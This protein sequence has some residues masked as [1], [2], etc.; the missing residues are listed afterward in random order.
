MQFSSLFTSFVVFAAATSAVMGESHK[1]QFVNKCGRGTPKLIQNG[2][3][4]SSGGTYTSNG[5]LTAAI[6]Y[7]QVG[8]KCGLNGENC[9]IVETTLRNPTSPGSGS[10]TDLSLIAPHKF[11]VAIKFQYNNG[12]SNGATCSNANCPP[13]DAFHKPSD[14]GAQRACQV[15]DA[16]LVITF[17]P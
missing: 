15:N 11:D 5:P 7:L 14:T 13:T 12:C 9:M 1:V 8:S 17:C 16:G 2:Q 3:T 4:L 6:A 10:S